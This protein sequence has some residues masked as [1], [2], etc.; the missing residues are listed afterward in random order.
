QAGQLEPGLRARRRGPGDED[1]AALPRPVAGDGAGVVGRVALLLVGGVVLLVDDDQA[2]V[3]DRGE[4]RRTRADADLRLAA[5]QALPLVEAFAVGE[6]AVEDGEAV[7]EA[8]A[9]ASDGLRRE[10]DLRHQDDRAAAAGE[11]RLD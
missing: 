10:A 1:G 8:G 6:G 7:A 9:E 11:R 4:D 3:A 2:E 5:A